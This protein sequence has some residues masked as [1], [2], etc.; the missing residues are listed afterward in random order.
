MHLDCNSIFRLLQQFASAKGVSLGVFSHTVFNMKSDLIVLFCI[1]VFSKYLVGIGLI[2]AGMIAIPVLL[3]S[4]SYAVAGSF[5]WPSSLSK[6]PWQNEGFYLILTVALLASLVVAFLG[7]EPLQLM[8]L[9][10]I[11][12]G[13]LAPILL[14]F[15]LFVG[16][17]ARIMGRHRFHFPTNLG[18][19]LGAFIL[20][21]GA[22][23]LLFG[24]LNGSQ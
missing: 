19:G 1:G 8:F 3:A 23:L 17:N 2:G 4:T 18:I 14:V 21:S 22:G 12:A 20:F 16:N 24:L 10:N 5:G 7:F 9:A 13:L 15:I 6:K 11:L